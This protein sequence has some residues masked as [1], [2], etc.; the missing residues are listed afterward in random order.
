M[1]CFNFRKRKLFKKMFNESAISPSNYTGY[2]LLFIYNL[3]KPFELHKSK[4]Q[5]GF[6]AW[7]FSDKIN[8]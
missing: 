2:H 4:E 8:T 6:I 1:N 7:I 3:L 5:R